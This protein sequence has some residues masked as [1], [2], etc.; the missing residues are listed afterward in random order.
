M[1]RILISVIVPVYGAEKYLNKCVSSILAQT[2]EQ[3]EI[4]LVDDGS[5]DRSGAMCDEYAV[6]DRRV[7]VLHQEN[8]GYERMDGRNKVQ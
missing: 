2:Y 7:R 3:L 4:I 1:D 8:G 5:K 6:R